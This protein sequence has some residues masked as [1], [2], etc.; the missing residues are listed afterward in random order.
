MC[1]STVRTWLLRS[2]KMARWSVHR[3]FFAHS[4]S[5]AQPPVAAVCHTSPPQYDCARNAHLCQQLSGKMEQISLLI[6]Q[7]QQCHSC[8]SGSCSISD[9]D[10]GQLADK[11]DVGR[12]CSL[13]FQVYRMR[14]VH[15]RSPHALHH[16]SSSDL[17]VR[18]AYSEEQQDHAAAADRCS[19]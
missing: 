2:A 6:R 10:Y 17:Q 16:C 1:A 8:H 7:G 3:K 13:N 18:L 14:N 15:Q 19:R 12:S 11:K 4:L 5:F 9:D